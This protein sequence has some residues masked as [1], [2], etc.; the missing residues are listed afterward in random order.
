MALRNVKLETNSTAWALLPS[1]EAEVVQ[2]TGHHAAQGAS[3]S[4]WLRAPV[5]SAHGH[6][7]STEAQVRCHPAPTASAS[8]VG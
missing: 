1:P 3:V 4:P 8:V 5:F 7:F 6:C 2:T